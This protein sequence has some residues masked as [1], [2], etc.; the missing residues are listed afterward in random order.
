MFP[1]FDQPFQLATDAS[2]HAIGAVLS[3]EHQGVQ[4]PVAFYLRSLQKHEKNYT[5][6]E[7]EGLAAVTAVRVFDFYLHNHPFELVIDHAALQHI[8]NHTNMSA[9]L[10]RW[11]LVL[12]HLPMIVH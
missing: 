7:K 5:V 10:A 3:Q 6:T 4:Q 8:F 1:R 12:Q 2:Q 9:Q 11:A